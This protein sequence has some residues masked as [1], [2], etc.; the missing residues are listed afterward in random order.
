MD[1]FRVASPRGKHEGSLM[2]LVEGG[3]RVFVAGIKEHL[4]DFLVAERGGKVH[5]G[6]GEA[7]W[8]D[9]G[10]VEERWMGL[11]DALDQQGVA[12]VDRAPQ[13][14]RRLDPVKA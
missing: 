11:E 6:V 1:D 4:A 8:R 10:I 3:T 9:I 13:S 5:V 7:D 2:V 12:G 14:N